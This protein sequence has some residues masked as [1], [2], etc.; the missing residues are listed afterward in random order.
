MGRLRGLVSRLLERMG[1]CEGRQ[2]KT[3]LNEVC[4]VRIWRDI[5]LD[6]L[7]ADRVAGDANICK[8]RLR[9]ERKRRR[10]ALSEKSLVRS[11]SLFRPMPAPCLDRMSIGPEYLGQVV[12]HAGSD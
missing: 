2:R 7:R 8:P 4:Y 3:P 6:V 11:Q 10:R 9:A 12:T 1:G 5:Q